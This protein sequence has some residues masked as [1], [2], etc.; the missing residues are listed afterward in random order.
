MA[1]D[2]LSFQKPPGRS[3]QFLCIRGQHFPGSSTIELPSVI[4][5][6]GAYSLDRACHSTLARAAAPYQAFHNIAPCLSRAITSRRVPNWSSEEAHLVNTTLR[7][8]N[9]RRV[10]IDR[11]NRDRPVGFISRGRVK[12]CTRRKNSPTHTP[13]RRFGERGHDIYLH[14]HTRVHWF[15]LSRELDNFFQLQGSRLF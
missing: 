9:H 14:P 10:S 2:Q 5:E 15:L 3:L 7:Q 6:S 11:L 4:A 8:Q 13:K 1:R 12:P